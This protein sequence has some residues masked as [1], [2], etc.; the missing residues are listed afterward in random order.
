MTLETQH[1]HNIVTM[2]SDIA[3]K[4]QPKPNVVTT[5]CAS[6]GSVSF[7]EAEDHPATFTKINISPQVF[8]CFTIGQMVPNCKTP[9]VLFC[10]FRKF[11][12]FFWK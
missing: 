9:H 10:I 4:K 3:T 1:C 11:Y 12:H 7:R 8:L 2:L 5:L 6:W